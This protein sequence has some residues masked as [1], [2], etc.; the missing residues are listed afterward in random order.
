MAIP[1]MA[2]RRG[3]LALQIRRG[4]SPDVVLLFGAAKKTGHFGLIGHL[5]IF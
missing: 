1:D 4:C 2:V 3:V 5:I